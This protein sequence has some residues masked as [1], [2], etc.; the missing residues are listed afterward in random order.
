MSKVCC[1]VAR[2]GLLHTLC[3]SGN[4][5]RRML[6]HT[7]D[8]ILPSVCTPDL[9]SRTH[10]TAKQEH[11]HEPRANDRRDHLQVPVSTMVSTWNSL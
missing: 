2:D 11:L 3:Q 1:D 10:L 9:L 6:H 7:A 5:E 8:T 4:Q